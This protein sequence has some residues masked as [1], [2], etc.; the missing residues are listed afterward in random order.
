[1]DSEAELSKKSRPKANVTSVEREEEDH[2]TGLGHIR[3][4]LVNLCE[5]VDF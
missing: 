1:V 2:E 3:Q 4:S 5:T